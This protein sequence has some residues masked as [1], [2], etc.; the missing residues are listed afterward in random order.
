MNKLTLTFAIALTLLCTTVANA[1]LVAYE[2]FDYAPTNSLNALNGGSG[3]GE[4]WRDITGGTREP[5]SVTAPGMDYTNGDTLYA[6]G[7]KGTVN[8]SYNWDNTARNFTAPLVSTAGSTNWFSFICSLQADTNSFGQ[9]MIGFQTA[10]DDSNIRLIAN[11]LG[12]ETWALNKGG[13]ADYFSSTPFVSNETLF[14]VI[15]KVNLV[16]STQDYWKAWINPPVN[17]HPTNYTGEFGGVY[18]AGAVSGMHIEKGGPPTKRYFKGFFDEFRVGETWDDVNTDEPVMVHTPVNQ[19][20]AN[21]ATGVS[22]TP[23]LT[24]S[25]FASD[26]GAD[27]HS[28]SRF[29]VESIDGVVAVDTNI[30]GVT[31]FTVPSGLLQE[32]TRYLWTV[33]YKGSH[34]VKWS[35][36]S[37]AT[38][39]DTTYATAPTP[40]SYDGA[41]YDVTSTGIDGY[42]GGEGWRDSWNSLEGWNFWI[43]QQD[44]VSPGLSYRLLDVTNN[45]FITINQVGV[46]GTNGYS[47]VERKLQRDGAASLLDSNNNFGN[48]NMTTW[49]SALIE[50]STGMDVEKNQYYFNLESES[51]IKLYI[52]KNSGSKYW[53]VG[54]SVSDVEVIP[55]EPALLVAKVVYTP[56]NSTASLWIDPDVNEDPSLSAVDATYVRN[57]SDYGYNTFLFS[58]GRDLWLTNAQGDVISVGSELPEVKFDEVRIASTWQQVLPGEKSIVPETPTNVA[59]ADGSANVS[60]D[61]SASLQGSAFSATEGGIS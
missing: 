27:S 39:F 35:A 6:K 41:A 37:A 50:A 2:P 26:D 19:T 46:G 7:N 33:N 28:A 3:W 53:Q 24:A 42:N 36:S 23:S 14:V 10:T 44:V 55:G 16:N 25:A 30:G 43:S 54:T 31:S 57:N 45:T 15:E 38:Y 51:G 18:P 29:H 22:L 4:A 59:P 17:Q 60:V 32:N 52:G 40:I 48:T 21:Y 47:K 49:V 58:V 5:C 1:T 34:S 20:P 11:G 9:Y 13:A 12:W 61:G 56:T 8:T